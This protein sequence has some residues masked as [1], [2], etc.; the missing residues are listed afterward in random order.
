MILYPLV[1]LQAEKH[2]IKFSEK[3]HAAEQN[4]INP[5]CWAVYDVSLLFLFPDRGEGRLRH[6]LSFFVSRTR[7][8]TFTICTFFFCLQNAGK[9]FTI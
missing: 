2:A 1:L 5:V 7:G 6:T 4:Y 3:L 9:D 8:G